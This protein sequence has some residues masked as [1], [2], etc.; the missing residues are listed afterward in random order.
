MQKFFEVHFQEGDL[1]E[2]LTRS[3]KRELAERLHCWALPIYANLNGARRGPKGYLRRQNMSFGSFRGIKI[4]LLRSSDEKIVGEIASYGEFG[5]WLHS[6][7][8]VD[9]NK[10][11]SLPRDDQLIGPY[12][13]DIYEQ[14]IAKLRGR[15]GIPEHFLQ[16]FFREFSQAGFVSEFDHRQYSF[17]EHRL[18]AQFFSRVSPV[19]EKHFLRVRR[20]RRKEEFV[21]HVGTIEKPSGTQMHHAPEFDGERFRLKS[22]LSQPYWPVSFVRNEVKLADLPHWVDGA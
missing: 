22:W 2:G 3:D 19:Q 12:I 8:Q 11:L 5:T 21:V 7:S 13:T 14:G 1:F 4:A 16:D 20:M 17:P 15:F 6:S 10:L 9:V 18:K